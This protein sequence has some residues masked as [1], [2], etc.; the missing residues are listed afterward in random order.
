LDEVL[1]DQLDPLME[2]FQQSAPAFYN[3]YQ[4]ARITVA[5]AAT[6]DSPAKATNSA[7]TPALASA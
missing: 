4:T 1:N 6:H 7:P 2:K 3:E 5:D